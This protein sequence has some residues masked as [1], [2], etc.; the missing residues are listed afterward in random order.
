[1]YS[2]LLHL[3]RWRLLTALVLLLLLAGEAARAQYDA[4]PLV[5]LDADGKNLTDEAGRG[6]DPEDG[7]WMPSSHDLRDRTDLE[8][9]VTNEVCADSIVAW[10]HEHNTRNTRLLQGFVNE[11]RQRGWMLAQPLPVREGSVETRVYNL[12]DVNAIA[13]DIYLRYGWLV[14]Y[15]C[16]ETGDTR[17]IYSVAL[18]LHPRESSRFEM[19]VL[20]EKV[21]KYDGDDPYCPLYYKNRTVL[22][23]VNKVE[24]VTTFR[25]KHRQAQSHGS[26]L[27]F[28]EHFNFRGPTDRRLVVERIVD[29]CIFGEDF[30]R[31][32][33]RL[34][35]DTVAQ[36]LNQRLMDHHGKALDT[37]YVL[38]PMVFTGYRFQATKERQMRWDLMR[39]T[40]EYYRK[41]TQDI[42]DQMGQWV[43]Y[44]EVE[45]D[46]TTYLVPRPLWK[47]LLRYP[48]FDTLR[49]EL[50]AAAPELPRVVA[51]GDT[52]EAY[53]ISTPTELYHRLEAYIERGHRMADR[54]A[55]SSESELTDGYIRH[56][57]QMD[58]YPL[59]QA[60]RRVRVEHGQE[61]SGNKRYRMPLQLV[62]YGKDTVLH[63]RWQ[64][65]D[66]NR[67][68]QMRHINYLHDF[69]HADTTHTD[70][71]PCER[72][73]P[74][75]FLSVSARPADFDCPPRRHSA[76]D[77]VV[78]FRPRERGEVQDVT[79]RLSLSFDQSSTKIDLSRGNN[80]QQLDS[81]VAKAYEI[82]HGDVENTIQQVEIVGVSS[83]EGFRQNN[84]CL[85]HGR[86][87]AIIDM[88][89]RMGGDDL[90]YARF[91]IVKDSVA[92]WSAVADLIDEMHPEFH[93]S[94]ERIREVVGDD[95]P[96][97]TQMQQRRLG[98]TN[99]SD[100][101]IAE[102]LE[103]LRLAQVTYAYKA[104]RDTPSEKI[105][106]LYFSGADPKR[107][108][109]YYFYVL[110]HSDRLSQEERLDLAR[111]LLELRA[112]DVRRYGR[113]MRP[114]DSYGLVLP[115]AANLLATEAI[116]EGNFDRS[117]LSPFINTQYYQGNVPCYMDNDPDT[118]V[119]FVNLDV[120]LYNQVLMLSGI[121]TPE[122]LEE[123]HELA[124]ILENTPTM[125]AAFRNAYRPELLELLLN[126]QSGHFVLDDE[127]ADVISRTNIC[128]YYVVNTARIYQAVDGE[129][130]DLDSNGEALAL[131]RQCGDSLLSLQR[132]MNDQPAAL[133]FTA[134]TEAWMAETGLVNNRD[135]HFDRA[136]VALAQLLG[137]QGEPAYVERL[138]GDSY[139]RGVYRDA[140]AV[141]E[142]MD[143]YLEAVEK[144]IKNETHGEE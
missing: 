30:D 127:N 71:C 15:W 75:L 31:L 120:V 103:K 44:R 91:D 111:K 82:T 87:E 1:M 17:G 6:W 63:F 2:E 9:F 133:Y 95:D 45:S 13:E 60:S 100:P 143:L 110:L 72:Q 118:P 136:V 86:S 115:Y 7:V 81:L 8:V 142:G 52:T 137:K 135:E 83:P 74:L 96:E 106:N 11:Y 138:Q 134:V 107:W 64:M 121:G 50:L 129:L 56:I 3:S 23:N 112:S 18:V 113:D 98:Y 70:E 132:Q 49:H 67:F 24:R 77:E 97:N 126:S 116:A 39:D 84:R 59:R 144:Y 101:L 99:G 37:S 141:R 43:E 48:S 69:V 130:I 89:R 104:L 20:N 12:A 22:E 46:T 94:A 53:T 51:E 16:R 88:L 5:I 10:S 124:D 34:K 90:R 40:M 139:L 25:K 102:A 32:D 78:T 26:W 62:P 93:S 85:S 117:I 38:E 119:K 109:S 35:G 125:S 131:L 27:T 76:T 65:P 21:T 79:Y 123:A 92:P 47:L 57:N 36:R 122:A 61:E 108:P 54:K 28:E 66:R 29:A 73:M 68:Y 19:I 80:Q 4:L 41:Q 140:K 42:F 58:I 105:L 114:K 33:A 55:I 14:D 128:N